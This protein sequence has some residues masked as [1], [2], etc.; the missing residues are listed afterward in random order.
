MKL[1][2]DKFANECGRKSSECGEGDGGVEGG[3]DEAKGEN[4]TELCVF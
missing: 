2:G 4:V 3:G 1:K